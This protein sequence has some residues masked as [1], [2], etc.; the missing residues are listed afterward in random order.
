MSNVSSCINC[1]MC[2]SVCPVLVVE[3][4]EGSSPRA[5]VLLLREK[6]L[7]DLLLKC[8]LCEACKPHCPVGI[9]IPEEVRKAR[10]KIETEANKKMIENLRKYGNPFGKNGTEITEGFY[11]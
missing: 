8:T 3:K 5:R 6:M 9:D 4:S 11:C 2:K 10:S 1:G 7:S